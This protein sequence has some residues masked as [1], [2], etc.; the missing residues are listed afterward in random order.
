M[1]LPGFSFIVDSVNKSWAIFLAGIFLGTF[2]ITTQDILAKLVLQRFSMP[3]VAAMLVNN[4]AALA[5]EIGNYFFNGGAY[6][7]DAAERA[8]KKAQRIDPQLIGPRY[9][10]S[11]IAFLRGNFYDALRLANEEL[12]L[13][14]E[15]KRTHYLLGLIYGYSGNHEFAER[16]FL[17][18]L[19]WDPK[20]WA[21]HNDLAWAYFAS[22]DFVRAEEAARSGLEHNPG[23]SWL[24]L[25]RGTA[26]LNLGKKKEAE[27]ALLA[28]QA[29]AQTLTPAD[30]GRAYPGNDP[31]LYAKGL[32]EMRNVIER[33][34]ALARSGG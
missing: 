30:W 9:Q 21:A 31:A 18:F 5:F 23:N 10:L 8:F 20:S 13:H 34:L 24:L 32:L 25:S 33:N 26:L 16:E 7:L 28:A 3:S 19:E 11:R 22:G 1:T 12:A 29:A 17:A 27:E 14:P 6:D 15:F 2:F 4:D